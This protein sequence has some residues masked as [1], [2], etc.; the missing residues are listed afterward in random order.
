MSFW[1]RNVELM[2][3]M[4]EKN[5]PEPWHT[6]VTAG[7]IDLYDVPEDVREKAFASEEDEVMLKKEKEE[8]ELRTALTGYD[9]LSMDYGG[10]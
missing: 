6:E 2:E 4:I 7:N 5:L 8:E 1:S 9:N 3:E 10:F